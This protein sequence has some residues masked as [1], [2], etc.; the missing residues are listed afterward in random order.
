MNWGKHTDLD[1]DDM[2]PALMQYGGKVVFQLIKRGD[3]Y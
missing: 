1:Y 2:G 3:Y